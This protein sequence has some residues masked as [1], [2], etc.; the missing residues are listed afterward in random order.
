[1]GNWRALAIRESEACTILR[2]ALKT[3]VTYSNI[4]QSDSNIAQT[5]RWGVVF[6]KFFPREA[7]MERI[8]RCEAR[9]RPVASMLLRQ[10]QI[11]VLRKSIPK[12]R[13]S[14]VWVTY[15]DGDSEVICRYD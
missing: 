2:E 7:Q 13:D 14:Q 3:G 8:L 1:M 9:V 15:T 4:P 6:A 5:V 10:T 11:P 12:R